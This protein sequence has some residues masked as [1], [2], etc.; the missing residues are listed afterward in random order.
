VRNHRDDSSAIGPDDPDDYPDLGPDCMSFNQT[1]TIIGAFSYYLTSLVASISKVSFDGN[2]KLETT[3]M[4]AD[5]YMKLGPE[6]W[7]I[8]NTMT[9][10]DPMDDVLN[11]INELAFRTAVQV[12]RNSPDSTFNQT[13]PYQGGRMT[14][15]Y[16]SDYK[17]VGIAVGLNFLAIFAIFPVYYGWWE[18]GRK[19][20]L[21]LLETAKAFGAPLLKDL[22]DNSTEQQI[23]SQVREKRVKY[24]DVSVSNRAEEGF[25]VP[26]K[27]VS[28]RL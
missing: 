10:K 27:G 17:L 25:F 8:D 9:Y 7:I 6:K 22:D 14:T 16:S 18:L 28:R 20:S 23:L 4:T 24:G 1:S 5:E 26:G 15:V 13:V 11:S 12:A 19:S 2:W 21:G 3:G